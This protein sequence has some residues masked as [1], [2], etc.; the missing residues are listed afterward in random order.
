MDK[1]KFNQM[2]K[3]GREFSNL[4]FIKIV[5][6]LP[7]FIFW[8]SVDSTFLGC[9]KQFAQAAGFDQPEDLIG[10]NDY[11]MPWKEYADKYIQDDQEVLRTGLPKYNIE[12][13]HIQ[14]DK[15][16]LIVLV[17]KIPLYDETDKIFGVFGLYLDI[18][19]RKN[20]EQELKKSK[21]E[22]ELSN[23]IKSEF[24]QNMQHDIRTPTA[25]IWALLQ[26][27]YN[28]EKDENKR[29]S[30]ELLTNSARQLLNFCNEIIDFDHVENN[31][32]PHIMEKIDLYDL[33]KEIIHLE[34][35]AAK[36]ANLQ[37]SFTIEENVPPFVKG[38]KFRLKRILINLISNALKFTKI[39]KVTL[40][41][42]CPKKIDHQIYLTFTIRDTGPGIS[43]HSRDLL[44]VDFTKGTPSGQSV[45]S[46]MGLGLRIVKKFVEEMGGEIEVESSHTVGTSFTVILP[47]TLPLLARSKPTNSS[48][49]QTEKHKIPL[50]ISYEELT[51]PKFNGH[52]L[53]VEDDTIAQTIAQ[54]HFT[55]LGCTLK[56]VGTLAEAQ[57]KLK[58]ENFDLIVLDLGLP[59]GC[60]IEFA[61]RINEAGDH[62]PIVAITAYS[63][64]KKKK[65]AAQAGIAKLLIK[66]LTKPQ[67]KDILENYLNVTPNPVIKNKVSEPTIDISTGQ[68]LIQGDEVQAKEMLALL[69]D[70]F[71][72]TTALLKIAL[73][74]KDFQAFQFEIH[75]LKGALAYCGAPQLRQLINYISK[76]LTKTTSEEMYESFYHKIVYEIKELKKAFKNLSL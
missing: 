31:N 59:D 9:N 50:K 1:I 67:A 33:V 30:L 58:Q 17:S 66:P 57:K 61:K 18:T 28:E 29:Q 23:K 37:L 7:F 64:S 14:A 4:I 32:C 71:T 12:E 74:S 24:I 36:A 76:T 22:A 25:G 49:Q 26:L 60:G 39:G 13:P 19:D 72:D 65:Q 2:T 40:S 68:L 34:S 75:K 54:R 51:N 46:G 63:D 35:A 27:M 3:E 48:S 15:K 16:K 42:T 41:I 70:S 20:Y 62:P 55:D 69:V 43:Q 38:D 73:E 8:K 47:F 52:I 45:L 44:F 21:R 56:L 11:D 10:K 53:I 5:N 6:Q